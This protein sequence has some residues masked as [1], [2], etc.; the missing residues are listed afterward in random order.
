MTI[1]NPSVL[2]ISDRSDRSRELASWIA[3]VCSCRSVG[4]HDQA[5]SAKDVAVIVTDVAFRDPGHVARLRSLL[6]QCR[7]ATTPIA[8]V[9]RDDNRH[10][11]VQAVALGATCVLP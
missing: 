8:A 4:L 5:H 11:Q 7:G 6:T 3:R 10:E 1:V 2:L 9:L